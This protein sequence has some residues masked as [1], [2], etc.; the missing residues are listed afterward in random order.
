MICIYRVSLKE[1]KKENEERGTR[2]KE[3]DKEENNNPKK[4][5]LTHQS[6]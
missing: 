6:Y 5:H 3:T 1:S 4:N 2:F